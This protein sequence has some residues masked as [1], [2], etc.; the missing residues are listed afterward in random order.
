M[1]IEGKD[2]GA[3][4]LP[5]EGKYLVRIT[6]GEYKLPKES[7]QGFIYQFWGKIEGGEFDGVQHFDSFFTRSQFGDGLDGA[8][9]LLQ[10]GSKAGV[11]PAIIESEEFETEAFAEKLC[12]K[13]QDRIVGVEIKHVKDKK[14]KDKVWARSS[15]FFSAK[16]EGKPAPKEEKPKKGGSFLDDEE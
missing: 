12:K 7:G 6:R 3:F 5:D 8:R 14:D 16:E 15:K 9:N 11:L 10:F 13:I 2:P 1:R 4:A